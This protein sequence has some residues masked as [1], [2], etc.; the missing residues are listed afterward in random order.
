VF[1]CSITDFFNCNVILYC[2]SNLSANLNN[3][4]IF[5]AILQAGKQMEHSFITAYCALVLGVMCRYSEVSCA[6]VHE[7]VLC[8]CV[9]L[10]VCVTCVI[11]DYRAVESP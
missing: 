6:C 5:S 4:L 7:C 10:S 3:L 2:L 8:V 11:T 1:Y 9:C